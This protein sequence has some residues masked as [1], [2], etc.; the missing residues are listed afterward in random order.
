M[1]TQ[2]TISALLEQ[3]RRALAQLQEDIAALERAQA[4]LGGRTG[5]P[6]A[7]TMASKPAAPKPA[8]PPAGPPLR[9]LVVELLKAS[10][11]PMS[12]SELRAKLA[13][14]GR[15][16]HRSTLPRVLVALQQ[17][18]LVRQAGPGRYE[19]AGPAKPQPT[20]AAPAPTPSPPSP[21]LSARPARPVRP[22]RRPARR[23]PRK[24]S[25]RR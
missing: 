6:A 3:K 8:A 12:P 18:G 10:A 2:A 25:P 24:P 15:P 20:S 7:G 13:A 5:T 14:R 11:T 4:L 17:Q 23:Q 19:A 16:C 9:T 22:G 21:S 1:A